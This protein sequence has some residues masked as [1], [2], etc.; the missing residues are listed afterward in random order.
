[1]PEPR[2]DAAKTVSNLRVN[3][4]RLW[5]S[6]MV[7]AGIGPGPKGGSHR[8]TLSE[9]DKVAR[10][11][12]VSW[13]EDLGCAIRIDS[14]GNVFA[15]RAGTDGTLPPVLIGSHLD[16]QPHGGRFDG[17]LGVLGALEVL[18]SLNEQD[19][20]TRHPVELVN[21]TNEE[22]S[23]FAPGLVGSGAYAGLYDDDTA[24]ASRDADGISFGDALKA[25]GYR[26]PTP[27]K[28]DAPPHAY[29]E[30]HIEQGPL[31]EDQE[32]D[33]GVVTQVQ[34]LRWFDVTFTGMEGHAGT[35]PMNQRR[36]AMMGAARLMER[37]YDIAVAHAPGAVAT[38]G[39]LTVQPGSRNVI[40]G[41]VNVAI[42]MRS[43][44]ADALAEMEVKLQTGA[45]LIAAELNLGV[46]VR[47]PI[48]VAPVAFDVKLVNTVRRAAGQ[49]GYRH[50]NI[51]SGALHD[52]CHMA[53]IAPAAMI[54][55]PCVKGISHNEAEDMRPEWATA[56]ANVLY[57]AVLETA[58]VVAS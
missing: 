44:S 28:H 53:A 1:M 11:L 24:C 56:G 37:V 38:V 34:G 51:V 13:C 27:A 5:S 50:R 2:A 55:S 31:L 57:H 36:D 54:F 48:R 25:I 19:I 33:V 22:G 3:G 18:R 10:D 43:P 17:V 4:T 47:V 8:L 32:V 29:F 52:A 41:S 6:L 14:V 40:P 20:R 39:A 45:T 26:G 16:T 35:I 9:D 7:V 15:R 21:W 12:L 23:R 58:G 30:L 46:E 49:L 42:D